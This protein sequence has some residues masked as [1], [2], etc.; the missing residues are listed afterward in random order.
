MDALRIDGSDLGAIKQ[1]LDCIAS[2]TR[3]AMFLLGAADRAA[4][5]Q[6]EHYGSLG[7]EYIGGTRA[8]GTRLRAT[9][10]AVS[11]NLDKFYEALTHMAEA[12]PVIAKTYGIRPAQRG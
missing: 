7:H 1:Y 2:M 3:N 11:G 12:L 4:L 8:V 5:R 9:A 6:G 10:D